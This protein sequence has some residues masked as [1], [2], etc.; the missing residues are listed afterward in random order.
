MSRTAKKLIIAAAIVAAALT[1]YRQLKPASPAFLSPLSFSRGTPES[2]ISE[3]SVSLGRSVPAPPVQPGGTADLE[4]VTKGD[5]LIIRRARLSLVSS[6]VQQTVDRLTE[7]ARSA[8][9]FTTNVNLTQLERAPRATVN[10]RVPAER[11]EEARDLARSLAVKVTSE[12]VTGQDVTEQFV[13]T[14]ARLKNLRASEE[15]FLAIMERANKIEDVLAVQ[16]QLERVRGQIERTQSR[17]Q[18]LERSAKLATFT[19]NIS[20][21][22]AYLPLVDPADRWRPKATANLAVRALVRTLQGVGVKL[23]WIAV[24]A[25]LWLPVLIALYLAYRFL[26]RRRTSGQK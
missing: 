16:Q 3:K 18:Y 24:F 9:G 17:L 26:G 5:R 15:Q 13:D 2:G 1:L 19:V 22:E 25:P 10:F 23:I 4:E 20:V 8:G 11:F 14:Q 6:D 7:F 12:Q 21:D